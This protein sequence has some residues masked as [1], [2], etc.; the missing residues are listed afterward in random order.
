MQFK[1]RDALKLHMALFAIIHKFRY[2][3]K[4]STPNI[5]ILECRGLNCSWRVYTTRMLGSDCYQVRRVRPEHSCSVDERVD[6]DRHA[7]TSVIGD[8]MRSRYNCNGSG[9]NPNAVREIMRDNHDVPTSYWKAWR[10]REVALDTA[11]GTSCSSYLR[12]PVY[13]HQL[14]ASNPETVVAL[15]TAPTDGMGHR[16]RYLFFAF[17]ASVSG[18]R[19][20]RRVVVID[21]THLKGKYGGC[22]ITASCQDGNYQI[23]PVAFGVVD[24]ENDSAWTWF[25]NKLQGIIP[26]SE[27]LSLFLID[28][29]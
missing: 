19:Y 28:T 18:L 4:I 27:G 3:N 17:G 24:S 20:M 10:S 21:G 22:L 5:M 14:I 8:V 7:T 15:E 13:L 12:L 11:K 16:F 1:D 23:F 9:P 6:Y 26:D 29:V 25:L 2:R